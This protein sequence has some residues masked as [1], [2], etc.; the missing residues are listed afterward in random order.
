[1][2]QW[3]CADHSFNYLRLDSKTFFNYHQ[4]S[5][6]VNILTFLHK[7][8]CFLKVASPSFAKT[9]RNINLF[10]KW[11]TGTTLQNDGQTD[12]HFH[13]SSYVYIQIIHSDIE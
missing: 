1:M 9:Q 8:T 11:V 3:S 5:L 10:I 4:A 2:L 7:K 12:G 13:K 6:D